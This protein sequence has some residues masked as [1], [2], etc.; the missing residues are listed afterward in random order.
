MQGLATQMPFNDGVKLRQNEGCRKALNGLL[1]STAHFL[2]CGGNIRRKDWRVYPILSARHA[3]TDISLKQVNA[4]KEQH[5]SD[6]RH[7]QPEQTRR[8]IPDKKQY[9]FF[10]ASWLSG[11]FLT[12]Q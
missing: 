3:D 9:P 5:Y 11:K 8:F 1:Y 12:A 4:S 6:A 2:H 7:C 10:I